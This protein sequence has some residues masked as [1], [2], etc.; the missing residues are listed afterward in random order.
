MPVGPHILWPL[1]ARKSTSSARTSTGKCG[2]D[3]ARVHEHDRARRVRARD[4]RLER[5]DRAERIGNVRE[6]D[7]LDAASFA[8]RSSSRCMPCSSTS[9]KR[10]FGAGL[11]G[12]QLPRHEVRMMLES[13]REDRV[14]RPE[15]ARAPAEAD[16]VDRFG[17]VARPDDFGGLGRV[18]EA[19]DFGARAFEGFGRALG[20]LVDAA[21][22]VRVVVRVVVHERVDDGL[23][24]LRTRGRIE[25]REALSARR[26]VRE[27]REIAG[28]GGG[29]GVAVGGNHTELRTAEASRFCFRGPREFRRGAASVGKRETAG[30]KKPSAIMRSAA[31]AFDAAALRVEDLLFGNRADRRAVK[32][33]DVIGGDFECRHGI[34]VR[35]RR[36]QQR[37]VA[38]RRLGAVRVRPKS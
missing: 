27:D 23:R 25:K 30:S 17:R 2:T 34:D 3:C 5:S 37:V 9:M 20:E 7:E 10:R 14:A 11:R 29:A 24:L 26:R 13:R 18:D 31:C 8:S 6:R 35:A 19:R 33:L 15:I 4:D 32:R 36:K 22:D 21:V 38:Q 1:A 12:E 28:D 16:E